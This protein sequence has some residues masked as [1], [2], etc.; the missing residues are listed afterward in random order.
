MA[1]SPSAEI[2]GRATVLSCPKCM[3]VLYEVEQTDDVRFCCASGHS[4][5]LNEICPGAE[6]SLG[7]LLGRAI[8]A[9]MK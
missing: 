9:L 3:G 2:A 5:A 1:G 7:R 6:D 4:Y 8:G